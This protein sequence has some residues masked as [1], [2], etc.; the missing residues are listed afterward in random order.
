MD[1]AEP[2]CEV[3]SVAGCLDVWWWMATVPYRGVGL[4]A[5]KAWVVRILLFQGIIYLGISCVALKIPYL[6]MS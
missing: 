1:R 4:T 2:Q 3:G 6:D 5:V